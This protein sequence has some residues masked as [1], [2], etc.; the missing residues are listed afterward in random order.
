MYRKH[1]TSESGEQV[2]GRLRSLSKDKGSKSYTPHKGAGGQEPGKFL[3][4][5]ATI[6]KIH[7]KFI[8]G[9]VFFNNLVIHAHMLRYLEHPTVYCDRL[10]S[11][12]V[13]TWRYLEHPTVYCDHL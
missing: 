11:T 9:S 5:F 6:L 13:Y 12:H 4:L 2:G 7:R 10:S 3:K 1:L 8:H